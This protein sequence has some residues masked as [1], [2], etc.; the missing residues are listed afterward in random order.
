MIQDEFVP[1]EV[2]RALSED[3]I[4]NAVLVPAMIQACLVHVSDVAER[5]Y[6][7]LR[8]LA[9]GASPIAEGTLR[10]AMEV[11]GCDFIQGYGMTESTCAVSFLSAADHRRA[12]EEKSELLLSAGR[13][14]L[15]VEIRVVDDHDQEVPRGLMGEIVV[16]YPGLM[17]RYWK[18]PEATEETLRGGW[19]HTGDAGVMDEEGFVY[20]QDRI[21]DMIV[22]GG[23]KRVPA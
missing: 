17:K 14:A 20:V 9:Y 1:A 3:H 16:R 7:D 21:K 6:P 22:S 2:V 18:R 12:V 19:L 15:G 5:K 23:E 13:A 4:H 8:W 11:F 10:K